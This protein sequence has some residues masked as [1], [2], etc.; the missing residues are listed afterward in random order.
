MRHV[1]SRAGVRPDTRRRSNGD[2]NRPTADSLCSPA[3]AAVT[4]SGIAVD[5]VKADATLI[6]LVDAL[7]EP[8]FYCVD[9]P[10]FGASLNL[11]SALTAHTCKPGA[12]DETFAVNQPGPGNLSMPAYDLCMEADGTGTL[13][14]LYLRA[15]S[16]SAMQRFDLDSH[17]SLILSGAGLCM[18]VSPG[19]GEP[20]GGPSHVRRDLLLLDCGAAEPARSRWVF[21]GRSPA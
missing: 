20:T 3:P 10:G 13:A 2:S 1:R 5:S 14:Q 18:A 21:P 16:D 8:E 7:D 6:Q 4:P 17:G 15:C 9:V 12:D 11:R 19:D